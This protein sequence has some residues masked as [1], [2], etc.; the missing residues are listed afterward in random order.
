MTPTAAHKLDHQLDPFR[1]PL[2]IEA[3]VAA[4]AI[5]LREPLAIAEL[6]R[7]LH[8]KIRQVSARLECDR[9]LGAE[10]ELVAAVIEENSGTEL[11]SI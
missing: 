3:M 7:D 4:Q 9:A 8:W 5:N 6:S 2:G 11:E 10:I 1:L